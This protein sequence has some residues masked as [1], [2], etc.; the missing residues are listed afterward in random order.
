LRIHVKE[1]SDRN[2]A[3]DEINRFVDARF[4]EEGIEIA[5]RQL[6]IHLRN[7]EGVDKLVQTRTG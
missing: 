4:K 5:F 1:L 3:I 2:P 6:D 7:S